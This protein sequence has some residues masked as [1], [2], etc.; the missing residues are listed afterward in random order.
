[1]KK[2]TIEGFWDRQNLYNT[3]EVLNDMSLDLLN[4][5]KLTDQQFTDLQITLNG[6]VK[7]GT[8]SVSDINYNLGKIGL[9]ELS[10]DVIKAIAGTA[11]VNAVVADKAVTT[12][13]IE[14]NAVATEKTDFIKTGKNIFRVDEVVQGYAVS[15]TT[16]DLS[17]SIFLIAP[18]GNKY[19]GLQLH[20][21]GEYSDKQL[22]MAKELNLAHVSLYRNLGDYA[23]TNANGLMYTD[24]VHP[25]KY[26][27]YAISNV[28][29]DRLLRL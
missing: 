22:S 12:P 29:Y 10:D 23:M 7:K 15:S 11:N 17:A 13:K 21:I 19:D 9:S 18:S 6:L 3:V 4:E 16:G 25:N 1:M 14:R 28:V 2:R 5:G 27:G 24:G 26:G 20:T 8:L